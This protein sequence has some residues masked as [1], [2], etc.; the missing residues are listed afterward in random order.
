MQWCQRGFFLVNMPVDTITE[1]SSVLD[2]Q[3]FFSALIRTD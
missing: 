2:L 3:K 1:S